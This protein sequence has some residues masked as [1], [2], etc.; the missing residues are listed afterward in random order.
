MKP[1]A[2]R[3]PAS[4]RVRY[5]SLDDLV[6]AFSGNLSRGGLFLKS[7]QLLPVGSEVTVTLE[8]PDGGPELQVPCAV[9][10]TR[11]TDVCG[12]GLRFTEPDNVTRERIEAFILK[13]AP[14]SEELRA[15][16]TRR[17]LDVVVVDDDPIQVK[18]ASS[19][20]RERGDTVRTARDGLEGLALCLKKTP[21]VVL[22]DVQMP[23]MDGWQFVRMLRS[24][25]AFNHVAIIFLTSLASED[26]RWLG[27]RL[28]VDDYLPKPYELEELLTRV[29]RAVLR[30]EQQAQPS[31]DAEDAPGRSLSGE[32]EQVSIASILSFLE[33][34]RRSG[35]L[36]IGSNLRGT[37]WL[38]DG[39]PVRTRLA[40]ASAESTECSGREA[41]FRLLS[42]S[43]G[44]FDFHE[45]DVEGPDELEIGVS[46]L[47]LEHARLR[48]EGVVSP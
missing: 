1:R 35:E 21:D 32:L 6:V 3:I 20:F 48:D 37:I 28:G 5:A 4:F 7:E 26:D 12:M 11:S 9:V 18:R 19:A 2:P 33:M 24:R 23:K 29:D 27:Y 36:R 8:L 25:P 41:I 40:D 44:R 10:F 31:A 34:E 22:T 46:A 30:A 13:A 43:A 15:E 39:R 42:V 38:R 14:N 45:G 16:A 47:L 17:A